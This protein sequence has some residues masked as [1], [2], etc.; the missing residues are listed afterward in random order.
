[1]DPGVLNDLAFV[2]F[3]VAKSVEMSEYEFSI[4]CGD[5]ELT[6]YVDTFY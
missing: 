1:L 2:A 3:D 6:L 5:A 4:D